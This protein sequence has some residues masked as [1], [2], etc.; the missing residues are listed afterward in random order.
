MCQASREQ[1]GRP[2]LHRQT[3]KHWHDVACPECSFLLECLL[4]VKWCVLSVCSCVTC[5]HVAT[6]ADWRTFNAAQRHLRTNMLH[7]YGTKKQLIPFIVAFYQRGDARDICFILA[8]Q[9]ISLTTT[10]IV[11]HT[12]QRLHSLLLDTLHYAAQANV[13]LSFLHLRIHDT[14]HASC[15]GD[16]T[17]ARLDCC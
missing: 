8:L 17:H 6:G 9:V 2:I 7:L 13:R 12:E 3:G 11:N 15:V 16:E 1:A 5:E 14:Y 10:Y 4:C